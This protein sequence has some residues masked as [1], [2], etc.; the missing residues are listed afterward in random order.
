MAR[1]LPKRQDINDYRQDCPL[2][3]IGNFQET[4]YGETLSENHFDIQHVFS[5]PALRCIQTCNAILQG[6]DKRSIPIAIE[7][8]F[9]DPGFLFKSVPNWL[10]TAELKQAGFKIQ[11]DYK[12]IFNKEDATLIIKEKDPIEFFQRMDRIFEELLKNMKDK[13]RLI[14][15]YLFILTLTTRHK[16]LKIVIR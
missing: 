11:S 12:Q 9:F 2:T 6:A 4:L 7:P 3:R 14:F 5:S 16:P 10:T 8:G 13:G 15:I 1:T